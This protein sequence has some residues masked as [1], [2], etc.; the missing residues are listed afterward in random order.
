GT[1]RG[2]LTAHG[3]LSLRCRGT[4]L[5]PDTQREQEKQGQRGGKHRAHWRPASLGVRAGALRERSVRFLR[6]AWP[7]PGL[8]LL[9]LRRYLGASGSTARS[10]WIVQSLGS[11]SPIF[12]V[13]TWPSM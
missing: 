12:F 9:H 6:A 13:P 7:G 5:L 8:R 2:G 1:Q 4:T 10:S 3:R 11:V